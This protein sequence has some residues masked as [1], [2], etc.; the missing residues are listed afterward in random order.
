ME[1]N[2][3]MKCQQE[4]EIIFKLNNGFDNVKWK[5]TKY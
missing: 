5:K 2:F 3:M 1:Q 4:V